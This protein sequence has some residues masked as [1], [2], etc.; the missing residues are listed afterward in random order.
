[1]LPCW[2]RVAPSEL[3]HAAQFPAHDFFAF[4]FPFSVAQVSNLNAPELSV[5]AG[6]S[7]SDECALAYRLVPVIQAQAH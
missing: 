3:C 6:C 2:V 7:V 4:F 5:D 1:M